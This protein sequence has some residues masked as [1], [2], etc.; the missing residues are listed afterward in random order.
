MAAA[1]EQLI[2][3]A[4]SLARQGKFAE[5][6]AQYQQVLAKF[7]ANQRARA[8]LNDLRGA[9]P[10][11][12]DLI[13]LYRQGQLETVVQQGAM[14]AAQFPAAAALHNLLGTAHAGLGD[15][16]AAIGRY[17]AA[18]RADPDFA[19]ARNNLGNALCAL[20]RHREAVIHYSAAL[21]LNPNYAEA[22]NNLGN[23]L[24]ALGHQQQAAASYRRALAIKPDYAEAH[25]NLGVSLYALGE[26]EAA[27]TCYAAALRLRPAYA[28]AHHNRAILLHDTGRSEEAI[29]VCTEALRINPRY[30]EAHNSW[31][32]ICNELRRFEEALSHCD[33]ALAIDPAHAG[34]HWNKSL[35]LLQ[36]G[37]FAEAW[38]L[39]EWRKR[40]KAPIAARNFAQPQWRG[41]NLTGKTLFLHWEQGLGDTLQFC[42]FVPLLAAR[43]AQIFLA[44]QEPLR[45]L[46]RDLSPQV[47]VIGESDVPPAFDYH[48]PLL[49]L[50]LALDL[51]FKAIPAPRAYL[52]ADPAA[53]RAWRDRLAAL[54]GLKA[55]LVWAGGGRK[56]QPNAWRVDRRRSVSLAQLAPLATLPGIS[57]VSLQKGPL[58]EQAATPPDGMML[59]DWTGELND[60][61]DTAALAAG[62]D[63]V[64]SVDTSTAHLA[65]ALGKPVWILSR[66]DQCWRWPVNRRDSAWYPSARLFQQQQPGDWEPVI[67]MMQQE[68]QHLT[69]LKDTP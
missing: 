38:P 39:Y 18:L 17:G 59:H 29:A 15:W 26:D 22:H 45:R 4:K 31:A 34:A 69:A 65:G 66:Y 5:A 16:D 1:V 50:P 43:G 9:A 46:L 33:A 57:F 7:P 25:N 32:G 14:L 30:A 24:E 68:L 61:A 11:L 35:T 55:G 51:D 40:K 47:S 56:D 48:C 27:A 23:A 63:L 44:V 19:G 6:A 67:A 20:G 49:S 3:K 8:G 12:G 28:E 54:P 64:I 37:R 53:A 13:A 36:L 42:R 21:R 58:A 52:H 60:F 2:A 41:E 10:D 62:L